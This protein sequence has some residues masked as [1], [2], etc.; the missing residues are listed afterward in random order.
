LLFENTV[1]TQ[2][3]DDGIWEVDFNTN[4][5]TETLLVPGTGES[6]FPSFR[7]ENWAVWSPDSTKFATVRDVAG[8]HYLSDG[9]RVFHETIMLFDRATLVGRSVLLVDHGTAPTGFTWS[10]DGNYLLYNLNNGDSV[11]IWWLDVATG[12]TGKVT[13]NGASIA[14]DWRPACEGEGC[15][16][17]SGNERVLLPFVKP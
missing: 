5:P 6:P 12:A 16:V 2:T 13:Q 1:P 3:R 8:Y 7:T 4:P 17:P 15:G 11:D 10:P 14:A 9:T